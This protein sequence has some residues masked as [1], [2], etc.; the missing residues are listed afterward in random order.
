MTG[1]R[2]LRSGYI[3]DDVLECL[4]GWAVVDMLGCTSQASWRR[5]SCYQPEQIRV[6]RFV[7]SVSISNESREPCGS[8]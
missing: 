8:I 5:S 3:R 6:L 1:D 7:G 2:Y 4:M